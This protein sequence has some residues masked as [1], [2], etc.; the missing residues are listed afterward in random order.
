MKNKI[1]KTILFSSLAALPFALKAG[2]NV[3]GIATPT[4]APNGSQ[5]QTHLRIDVKDDTKSLHLVSS[6]NNP[7]ILTKAYVLKNADPY[8]LVAYFQSAVRSEQISGDK[9]KVEAIKY[10]DGSGILIVSAEDYRFGKQENGLGFDETVAILDRP[11]VTNS[12]GS[13]AYA[14]F[15]KYVSASW[16]AERLRN[17]GLNLPDQKELEGGKDKI[18]VDTPLNALF[19]YVPPYQVKNVNEMIKQYDGAIQELK[20]KYTI[21]ELDVEKDG[22]LGLDVQ[23]W[24]NGPGSDLVSVA[25]RFGKQW[26]FANNAVAYPFVNK[27]H[28]QFIHFSPKWNSKYFDFLEAK[29]KAA[30]LTY[31]EV[32]IMNNQDA[33]IE[34]TTRLPNFRD[35]TKLSNID[36]ISY[37]RLSDQRIYDST[38]SSA[39]PPDATG[40]NDG[41]YRLSAVDDNGIPVT[42]TEANHNIGVFPGTPYRGD[43]Q[44]TKFFDGT[45]YHYTLE[46]NEQEAAAQGV[47]FARLPYPRDAAGVLPAQP[48][49]GDLL[50]YTVKVLNVKL[51][52]L[53]ATSAG[54]GGGGAA[55]QEAFNYAW[56]T[57]DRYDSSENFSIG[58]GTRQDTAVDGYGFVLNLRPVVNEQSST[59]T[60]SM[61]NTSLIGFQGNGT[62]RTSK[63]EISTQVTVNNDGGQFVVGGVE[64]KAIVKSINKVPWLGDLPI[65]G[66]ALSSES[67]TSKKSQIV[68]VIEA[69]PSAPETKVPELAR[70]EIEEITANVVDS[71]DKIKVGFDQF[72]LDP[73]KKTPDPLP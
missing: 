53:T 44:I 63:S 49:N 38:V 71:G 20:V 26:D 43:L 24:K 69:V 2:D 59:L 42:L 23:A 29:G 3:S 34:A 7:N 45:H 73:D 46:L 11:G 54:V 67:T 12:A 61:T 58:R 9:A 6:T 72:I 57:Y 60:I 1:A 47:Q 19:V 21:Y 33:R 35:G 51:E 65:I 70:R 48:A 22:N 56:V 62:P 41:R 16:L 66:W 39:I 50:G 4:A 17:V 68:A 64:K 31:G 30:V 13:I 32:N 15:P 36:V 37:I 55:P 27:S 25:S 10:N 28:T 14:Y 5:I 52:R 18:V 8:E 40:A